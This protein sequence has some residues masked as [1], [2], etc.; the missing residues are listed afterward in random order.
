MSS[1]ESLG[2]GATTA[3]F[4]VARLADYLSAVLP[5][6]WGRMSLR[7]FQ[8]GQSN[9]TYLIE[10]GAER[11]VLRKQPGGVLLPSA[12]AVDREFTIMRALAGTQVPVPAALHLATDKSIIGT[13]FFIMGYMPGRV[14]KDPLLPGMTI[15]ERAAIH[16][17]MNLTLARIHQVDVEKHGLA[18]FGR[19]GNYFARQI[20]RWSRQYRESETTPMPA[21]DELIERL[22][23]MVPQDERSA[24][25]HGDYRIENLI[26]HPQLPEV[27][28][29]V[30]WELA[31]LGHPLADLAYNCFGY[32]LPRRAFGGF[33]DISLAAT[34]VP[35]EATYVARYLERSGLALAAPWGFY[36]AFA[37]FRLAAILQGVKKRALEGHQSS[38]D[39]LER[40]GFA[41][42]CAQA[43]V[44]ALARGA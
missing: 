16:D 44:A 17:A 40:G 43:G 13:L 36:I 42:L 1:S 28:A 25:A 33:A 21:M 41:E 31:T 12:H 26:Y 14:F 10:A 2:D 3:P 32:H 23:G 27:V 8:G 39:A 34:G 7:A 19:P 4:D 6:N 35:D 30:D 9:P 20:A 22:P 11:Y 24:I 37:M 15:D 29:V 38:P 18:D 5:G